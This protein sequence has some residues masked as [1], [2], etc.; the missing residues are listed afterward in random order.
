MKKIF[1]LICMAAMAVSVNA[2]IQV[3]TFSVSNG[4]FTT[5]KH[6]QYVQVK[7]GDKAV[8]NFEILSSPNSDQLYAD[9]RDECDGNTTPTFDK[10]KYKDGA[11]IWLDTKQGAKKDANE[12]LE[13]LNELYK[14]CLIGQGNP[15]FNVVESW[16]YGDNGWS[17]KVGGD[18]WTEGCGSLPGQGEYLRITPI[19]DGTVQIGV[20]INKGGHA[21]YI[22]DESTK[23]AGYTLLPV[24]AVK[25]VG[26]YFQN[27][28]WEGN[29]KQEFLE[30]YDDEGKTKYKFPTGKTAVDLVS[31]L[32]TWEMPTDRI[33]QNQ[34]SGAIGRPFMGI[35]EFDVKK[36]VSYIIMNP[37]SQVG[38]YGFAYAYDAAAAAAEEGLSTPTEPTLGLKEIKNVAGKYDADAPI[39][40]LAGQKVDKSYK[41]VK[42]QNGK[43]FF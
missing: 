20:Y 28:T 27:N 13:A 35:I 7:D 29:Y 5:D 26:G 11:Q 34:S 41:G 24:S 30:A 38:F 14:D 36:G 4:D 40:N 31:G 33:I 19:V 12:S 25:V 2:Q 39:Y 23:A 21:L 8:A 18:D 32:N 10:S 22:I 43:K 17:F 6:W 37:K 3:K 1:T 42:V 15:Q 9:N 16:S